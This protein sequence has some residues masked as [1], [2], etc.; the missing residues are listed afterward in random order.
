MGQLTYI[1]SNNYNA[2]VKSVELASKKSRKKHE[3]TQF[4]NHFNYSIIPKF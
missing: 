4:I 1:Y 2:I 3:K